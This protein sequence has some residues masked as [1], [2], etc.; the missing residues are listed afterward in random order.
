MGKVS[1]EAK[2]RYFDIVKDYKQYIEQAQTREKNVL[3]VIDRDETGA[4]YKRLSLAEER[5]NLASQYLL[6]NR[7]SLSLLGVKNEAFLNDA[8]KC[9]YQSIIYLEEVVTGLVDAPFSDYAEN[10]DRIEGFDD[11]E[12]YRL[13]RKLGFTIDS[14]EAAFG[15]KSKWRWSFVEL[16]ARFATVTKNLL[17]LKTLV[18]G[19]D[20]R[21]EGFEDRMGHLQLA[22]DL[23]RKSADR[24][25]EKYELSTSRMD[26][27]KLAIGYLNALRRIHALLGEAEEAENTKKKAE[28]WKQKMETDDKR[29]AEKT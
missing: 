16:E 25:R 3:Q 14:V 1:T 2:R 5:L 23:L 28:V 13:I 27:F 24:Y 11:S 9:C 8:R 10:H 18:A 4:D 29:A 26:D 7:I 21:V 22:K 17:N 20:P 6:L 19:L 12:R 15:E